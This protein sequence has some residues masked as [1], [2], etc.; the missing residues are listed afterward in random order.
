MTSC[1]IVGPKLDLDHALLGALCPLA[2][3]FGHFLGLAVADADAALQVARNDER[4]EREAAA[5]LDDLGHA[6]DV[7]D[8]VGVLGNNFFLGR[9]V[10]ARAAGVSATLSVAAGAGTGAT[11][12]RAAGSRG[13]TRSGRCRGGGSFGRFFGDGSRSIFGIA[14]EIRN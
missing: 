8:L 14:H 7:H 1:G 2:D 6:V 3:G 4:G 13:L 10:A 11:A 12:T 5:A 9:A